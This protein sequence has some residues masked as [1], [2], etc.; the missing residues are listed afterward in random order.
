MRQKL[1][2]DPGFKIKE[3][4]PLLLGVLCWQRSRAVHMD[5][6]LK[7][8]GLVAAGELRLDSDQLRVVEQLRALQRRLDGYQLPSPS[9][10]QKVGQLCTLHAR[11]KLDTHLGLGLFED[12]V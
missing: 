2:G 9:L 1:G 7:Y 3:W 12:G 10:L 11:F 4:L 5:V 6:K 8:E